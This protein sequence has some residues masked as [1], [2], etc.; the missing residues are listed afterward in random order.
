[1]TI[2]WEHEAAPGPSAAQSCT[3]DDEAFPSAAPGPSRTCASGE[4]TGLGARN[5]WCLLGTVPVR[6]RLAAGGWRLAAGGWRLAAAAAA[7]VRRAGS[8]KQQVR[9]TTSRS[10]YLG[11]GEW[12]AARHDCRSFHSPPQVA[13]AQPRGP[14]DAQVREG[15][16]A[17]VGSTSPSFVHACAALGPGAAPCSRGVFGSARLC[18]DGRA[19]S[20]TNVCTRGP[21]WSVWPDTSSREVHKAGQE[22]AENQGAP[23]LGALPRCRV[24]SPAGGAG[25]KAPAGAAGAAPRSPPLATPRHNDPPTQRPPDTTAP[26]HNDPPTELSVGTA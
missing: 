20:L 8:R 22:S 2:P 23:P 24:R 7:A 11:G 17:A 25:G 6:L 1:L 10:W 12:T 5:L 26:R 4:A 13:C 18:S 9:P 14:P 16:G 19:R 21:P 3:K 15:P